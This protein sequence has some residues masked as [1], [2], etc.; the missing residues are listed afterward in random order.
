MLKVSIS[1]LLS[2]VLVLI[3]EITDKGISSAVN[4]GSDEI[5]S[6]GIVAND[7]SCWSDGSFAT[8]FTLLSSLD[9]ALSGELTCI[10]TSL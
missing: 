10:P 3:P 8:V 9:P 4:G 1:T 7:F 5:S 6:V 2:A